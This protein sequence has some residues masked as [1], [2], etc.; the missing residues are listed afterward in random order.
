MKRM[1]IDV[2]VLGRI[3]SDI[4]SHP[5]EKKETAITEEDGCHAEKSTIVM[6]L[7]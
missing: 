4:D 3:Y 5:E 6:C 7:V 1:S 2:V